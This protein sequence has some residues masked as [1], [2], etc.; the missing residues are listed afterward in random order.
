V[1]WTAVDP[2]G[3]TAICRQKVT[4]K[5][6]EAPV[7][8]AVAASPDT[9]KVPNHKMVLVA[10]T[11]VV[12]DNSGS[13]VSAISAVTSS[14]PV[15]GAGDGDQEP[16]WEIVPNSLQVRLRAERAQSGPGR[17]YTITVR[18]V[19]PSGNEGFGSVQVRVPKSASGDDP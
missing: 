6:L 3:R 4:V 18:C 15:N 19:D 7:I 16:D 2:A 9:L 11:V 10:A 5:D 14:E 13:V 8:E 12:R 17:T 1:T